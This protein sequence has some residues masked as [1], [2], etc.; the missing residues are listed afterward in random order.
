[1]AVPLGCLSQVRVDLGGR[2]V[3]LFKPS[4]GGFRYEYTLVFEALGQVFDV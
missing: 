4:S 2:T 1:M 3:R